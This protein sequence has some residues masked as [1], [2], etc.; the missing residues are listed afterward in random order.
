MTYFFSL[1]L[2]MLSIS[3]SEAPYPSL[4]FFRIV[5]RTV[6]KIILHLHNFSSPGPICGREVYSF[7]LSHLLLLRLPSS[8]RRE[9]ARMSI[10]K[11]KILTSLFLFD[12][13]VLVVS[14]NHGR[15]RVVLQLSDV[16]VVKHDS[17]GRF[18]IGCS[19]LR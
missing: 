10:S 15:N 6:S 14:G 16:P 1:F 8:D 18:D 2:N 3:C 19:S 11:T 9:S 4:F 13:V 7:P 5:T 17:T 12:F